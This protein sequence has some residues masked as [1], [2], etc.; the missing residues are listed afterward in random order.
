MILDTLLSLGL[1]YVFP[2][3]YVDGG[4]PLTSFVEGKAEPTHRFPLVMSRSGE[5]WLKGWKSLAE[6]LP[7]MQ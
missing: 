6:P 7:V 5:D 1:Q 4:N 3:R 2:C